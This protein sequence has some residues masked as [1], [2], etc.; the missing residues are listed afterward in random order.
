MGEYRKKCLQSKLFFYKRFLIWSDNNSIR[1]RSHNWL[2]SRIITYH[3][4]CIL[5]KMH[6]SM[7][8]MVEF[9]TFHNIIIINQR[10][11]ISHRIFVSAILPDIFSSGLY[12]TPTGS[13]QYFPHNFPMKPM[14]V[15]AFFRTP[16]FP[17]GRMVAFITCN[18]YGSITV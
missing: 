3:N 11:C 5:L 7:L 12:R 9:I 17:Y 6:I 15:R 14:T 8:C 13:R 10:V 2:F 18:T 1:L 16:C 4:N